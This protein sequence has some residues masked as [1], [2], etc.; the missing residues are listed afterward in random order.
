M[1]EQ[2]YFEEIIK[3]L[4][5]VE[6]T[7]SIKEGDA[8]T[9]WRHLIIILGEI[10]FNEI[11]RGTIDYCSN[12]QGSSDDFCAI[13]HKQ[14]RQIDVSDGVTRIDN[15]H[16]KVVLDGHID[17]LFYNFWILDNTNIFINILSNLYKGLPTEKK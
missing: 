11:I 17:M 16:D 6:K 3:T 14:F 13:I 4:Q 9:I 2:T 1:K 7:G 8:A 15:G 5:D 12:N 10:R